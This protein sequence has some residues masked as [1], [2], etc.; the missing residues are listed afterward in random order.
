MLPSCMYGAVRG[1][2]AQRWGLEVALPRAGI[3]EFAV[4]PGDA[5]VVQPLIGKVRADVAGDAVR[6]PTK[7]L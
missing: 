6:L 1:D 5:G 2:L 3:G 4:A 7:E